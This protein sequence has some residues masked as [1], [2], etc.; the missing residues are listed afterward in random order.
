MACHGFIKMH[1]AAPLALPN[2]DKAA[3]TSSP[4]SPKRYSSSTLVRP[5]CSSAG[6]GSGGVKQALVVGGTEQALAL[7]WQ[8]RSK[9]KQKV[10]GR[11]ACDGLGDG[12]CR[13]Q[14]VWGW[15]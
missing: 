10:A 13:G 7:S 1:A 12:L 2:A 14:L 8:S 3:V 11:T 4:P 5:P 6:A 15:R 9:A